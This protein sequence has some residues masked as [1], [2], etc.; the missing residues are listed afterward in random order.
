MHK[1]GESFQGHNCKLVVIGYLSATACLYFVNSFSSKETLISGALCILMHIVPWDE[2][3][4]LCIRWKI[5]AS[6]SSQ[7]TILIERS[8]IYVYAILQLFNFIISVPA[9]MFV[10]F[11]T[12]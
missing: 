8:E 4:V 2:K 9:T 3:E 10:N 5:I 12:H 1:A 6:F 7:E 11:H